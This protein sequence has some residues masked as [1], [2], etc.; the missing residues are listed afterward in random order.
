[1]KKIL[2]EPLQCVGCGSCVAI[3]PTASISMR[4]KEGGFLYPEIDQSTC[5]SCGKCRNVCPV[6]AEKAKKEP[7]QC[8]ALVDNREASRLKSASGAA[9]IL[10]AEQILEEGGVFCG[11]RL[12]ESLRA[13]HDVTDALDTLDLYRDSKYVQSDMS[14]AWPKIDA[15]LKQ[16]KKVLVSGAPC[17]IDAVKT[18]VGDREELITCDFV[19]SGVPDPSV[20]ELYKKALEKEQGKAIQSFYFRDKTN[21]WKKSNIRVVYDDG[22]E[23]IIERKNSDYFRL[24]GNNLFFRDCCY[25]CRFKNFNTSADLTVGDYWGIERLYPEIDDDKGCSL[26]IV[27]TE[28]GE[29]LLSSIL[30]K[31]TVWQTPLAFAIET[32]PKLEKSIPKSA[33]RGLFYKHYKGDEKSLQKAIK[34]SMGHSILDKIIRK[35]STI[36]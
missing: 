18:R 10:F 34:R 13:V 24:F 14:L 5:V 33:Y 16:G 31:A 19:C 23:Q 25:N 12:D 32:H 1:M 28:K 17:Q 3:C 20:F 29:A 36:K 21:G 7:R 22:S 8:Y 4:T 11:C 27:N 26:V 9:S 30:N 6:L 15:A 35:I 2:E